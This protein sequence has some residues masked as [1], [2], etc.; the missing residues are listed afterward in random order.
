MVYEAQVLGKDHMLVLWFIQAEFPSSMQQPISA[1]IMQVNYLEVW[2]SW[3]LRWLKPEL[4]YTNF[5][6]PN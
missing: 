5:K 2:L 4:P 1:P 6:D 3:A